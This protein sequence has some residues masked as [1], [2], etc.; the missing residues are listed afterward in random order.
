MCLTSRN[1]LTSNETSRSTEVLEGLIYLTKVCIICR[2]NKENKHDVIIQ[3]V[4]SSQ[5]DSRLQELKDRGYCK[6]PPT[7][8][9]F[10][11]I[12]GEEIDIHF[13]GNIK[14]T[15]YST[16]PLKIKFFANIEPLKFSGRIDIVDTNDEPGEGTYHGNMVYK[17]LASRSTKERTGALEIHFKKVH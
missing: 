9:E 1:E 8:E 4:K 13:E 15:K 14:M 17:V 16:F 11:V 5:L 10:S 3:C 2:Q 6:G 12:D 7:S